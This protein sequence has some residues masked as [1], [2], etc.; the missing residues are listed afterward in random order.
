[1]NTRRFITI[2]GLAVSWI[3]GSHAETNGGVIYFSG[4]IVESPCTLSVTETTANTQCYRNGRHYQSRQHTLSHFDTTRKN[5]PLNLG[6]TEM[7]WVNQQQKLA[8][9][10]VVYR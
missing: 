10:T 5:L 2:V 6:S 8:V 4:A 9:M 1:M 7:G 3:A